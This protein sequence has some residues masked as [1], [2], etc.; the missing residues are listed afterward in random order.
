MDEDNLF[1]NLIVLSRSSGKYS[2]DCDDEED[3]EVAENEGKISD[4]SD[5][6]VRIR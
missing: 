6:E 3:K 2:F 5:N 4:D 1:T